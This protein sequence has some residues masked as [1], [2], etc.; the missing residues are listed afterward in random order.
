MSYKKQRGCIKYG[1]PLIIHK[2][3]QFMEHNVYTRLWLYNIRMHSLF[4]FSTKHQT[5]A[6]LELTRIP[7]YYL[8]DEVY[9]FMRM[10]VC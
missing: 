9:T 8:F 3:E 1:I 6:R 2:G 5:Y 10:D 4:F 7:F